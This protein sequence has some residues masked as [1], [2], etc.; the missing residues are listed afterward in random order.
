MT[1]AQKN[2]FFFA[3]NVGRLMQKNVF[4]LMHG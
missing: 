1:I 3:T 4:V 2:I